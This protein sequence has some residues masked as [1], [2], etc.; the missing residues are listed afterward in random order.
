MT[1]MLNE[2]I[3]ENFNPDELGTYMDDIDEMSL[4]ELEEQLPQAQEALEVIEAKLEELM[5]LRDAA[6]VCAAAMSAR[7]AALKQAGGRP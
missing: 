5:G 7:L 6:L 3:P 1:E 2:R 4:D